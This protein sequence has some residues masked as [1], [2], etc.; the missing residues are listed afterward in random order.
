M[1]TS[2]ASLPILTIFPGQPSLELGTVSINYQD[3]AAAFQGGTSTPS[4]LSTVIYIRSRQ[5]SPHLVAP[6]TD[7][8]GSQD[9]PLSDDIRDQ[10]DLVLRCI[11]LAF[12]QARVAIRRQQ[13]ES[14]SQDAVPTVADLN[15]PR[16]DVRL[17]HFSP[18]TSLRKLK[19]NF[20]GPCLFFPSFFSLFFFSGLLLSMLFSQSL[21]NVCNGQLTMFKTRRETHTHTLFSWLE[22]ER[23]RNNSKPLL[24]PALVFSLSLF[25]RLP[26]CYSTSISNDR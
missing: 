25:V 24:S 2:V 22:E 17:T 13:L 6:H 10:P 9:V 19:A 1:R 21:C 7:P 14:I 26:P 16:V 15:L 3:M 8:E 18:V 12:Y 5:P 20:I 4:F 11:S 23:A